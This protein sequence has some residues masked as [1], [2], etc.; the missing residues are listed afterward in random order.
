MSK[1]KEYPVLEQEQPKKSHKD[2]RTE[3]NRGQRST[4]VK[5]KNDYEKIISIQAKLIRIQEH[6]IKKERLINKLLYDRYS[7]VMIDN[8]NWKWCYQK[9]NMKWVKAGIYARDR[10]TYMREYMK[11]KRANGEIKHW[12]QYKKEKI[13][14]GKNEEKN[15]RGSKI[16]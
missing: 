11:K 8:G 13:M 2:Q 7:D 9:L 10:T 12:R 14:K 3:S 5:G 6:T 1:N 15:K 4:Q 16:K